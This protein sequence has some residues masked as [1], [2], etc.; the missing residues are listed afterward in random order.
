MRLPRMQFTVGT[1]RWW[2]GAYLV[3]TLACTMGWLI[4]GQRLAE[5]TGLRRQVWLA[6]DFQGTPVINDVARAA[7][8]DFLDDDPRLP[9]EFMSARWRGYWYLPSPQSFTLHVHADDYADIWIDRERR[10][11]RSSAA[12]RAVRLDAGVHELQIVYQQ[13]AGKANLA[14]YAGRGSAYPLPLRT[15]YLFPSQPKPNLQR[16]ATIVDRLKLTTTVLWAGSALGAAVFILRRRRSA[17]DGNKGAS[18]AAPTRLDAVALTALCL[19]VLVYGY[20]NL[21]LYYATGDGMQQSETG[22]QAGPRRA[23]SAVALAGR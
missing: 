21:S 23:V 8:L 20:G 10:F 17:I 6:N 14:L 18:L 13:Y 9:R 4:L 3:V 19:T 1:I 22:H 12:A 11:S 15:G 2:V 7:T 16:L 5:H